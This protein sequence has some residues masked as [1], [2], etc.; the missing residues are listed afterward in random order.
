MHIFSFS[1]VHFW[2]LRPLGVWGT[3]KKLERTTHTLYIR[4]YSTVRRGGS[5][6]RR[7]RAAV[8]LWQWCG[9]HH[10]GVVKVLA[11]GR[12]TSETQQ[13]EIDRSVHTSLY[14]PA[15]LPLCPAHFGVT[16][17]YIVSPKNWS[18][19]NRRSSVL[20]LYGLAIPH[21]FTAQQVTKAAV[22]NVRV[23]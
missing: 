8:R 12:A 15:R 7:R 16:T 22:F 1:F 14:R 9:K 18:P 11:K 2:S 23:G 21:F 17:N 20:L 4:L 13:G 10:H 6:C 5:G 19:N 3:H